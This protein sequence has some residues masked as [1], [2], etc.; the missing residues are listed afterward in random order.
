MGNFFDYTFLLKI[1]SIYPEMT[2]FTN[3]MIDFVQPKS[4]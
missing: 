4:F 1:F 2:E 3:D